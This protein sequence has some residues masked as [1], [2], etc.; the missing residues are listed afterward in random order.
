M[1]LSVVSLVVQFYCL[2]SF[3]AS[4]AGI[5]QDVSGAPIPGAIALL[6]SES[7]AGQRYLERANVRGVYQFFNL[8]EGHYKL[9][10]AAPGFQS[11]SI[12]SI[13]IAGDAPKS[14]QLVTLQIGRGCGGP[15]PLRDMRL[16]PAGS[17]SGSLAGAV[18]NNRGAP[19]M[20]A[21]VSLM[22][23]RD[24]ICADI[25][26]NSRGEFTFANLAP[27][28]YTVKVTKEGFYSELESDLTV[29]EDLELAYAPILIDKCRRGNCD[30]ALRPEPRASAFRFASKTPP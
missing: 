18:Q 25:A 11:K 19:V 8:A 30:P 9:E 7:V 24:K 13:E 26:T 10:L 21:Q 29:R 12:S 1:C 16:L 22:C 5:A 14:I 2:Q 6:E 17:R 28:R 15:L 27:G 20:E 23:G 4:L 3:G